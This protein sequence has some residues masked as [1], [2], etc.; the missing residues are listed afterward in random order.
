MGTG[1][2]AV[3]PREVLPAR[4]QSRHDPDVRDKVGQLPRATISELLVLARA[5]VRCLWRTGG[6]HELLLQSNRCRYCRQPWSRL[7]PTL[8]RRQP[9]LDRK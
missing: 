5:R 6:R 7:Y 2:S 9:K 3:A 8:S 4:E 1:L